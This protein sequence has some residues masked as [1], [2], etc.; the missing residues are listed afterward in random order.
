MDALVYPTSQN[1]A[2]WKSQVERDIPV[3]G[4]ERDMSG[5]VARICSV[6]ERLHRVDASV[7]SVVNIVT[8]TQKYVAESVTAARSDRDHVVE[9]VCELTSQMSQDLESKLATQRNRIDLLEHGEHDGDFDSDDYW[10][11]LFKTFQD[12]N[13]QA[14]FGKMLALGFPN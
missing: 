3:H 14:E 1:D 4:V 6:E 13:F 11:T 12:S 2:V 10:N 7:K 9:R 8:E 5:V